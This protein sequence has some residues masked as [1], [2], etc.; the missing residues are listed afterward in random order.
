VYGDPGYCLTRQEPPR[1]TEDTAVRRRP[2]RPEGAVRGSGPWA[3]RTDL[4]DRASD[5]HASHHPD[6]RPVDRRRRLAVERRPRATHSGASR[7]GRTVTLRDRQVCAVPA[8]L[9][10]AVQQ[11]LLATL[12]HARVRGE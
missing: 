3:H 9:A 7:G 5:Q 12:A 2:E 10:C 4:T 11:R 1:E 8:A 6:H